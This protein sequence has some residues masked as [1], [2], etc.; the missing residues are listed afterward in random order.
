M[1]N[2]P[3]ELVIRTWRVISIPEGVMIFVDPRTETLRLFVGMDPDLTRAGYLVPGDAVEKSVQFDLYEMIV[4][5]LD[6]EKKR[7][8]EEKKRW[9]KSSS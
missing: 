7:L 4:K 2:D 6:E 3:R 9:R 8:E 1:L 5:N